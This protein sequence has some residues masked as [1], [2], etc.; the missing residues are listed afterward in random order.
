MAKIDDYRN[1]KQPLPKQY[2]AWQVFGA[3][4]ENVGR[5]GKPTTIEM[6]EPE[7]NEILIRVDVL[8]LCLSD[9]KI[10]NQ[11]S[12]HPRL[13]GRDLASDPTVLG[14][15]C[16]ATVVAVGESWKDT[17]KIGQRYIVQADHLLQ[18]RGLRIRLSHP[19]RP[20]PVLLSRR[21]RSG[22]R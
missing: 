18:R 14:H 3:G 17:F 5:D 15:E 20:G 21:A 22:R 2:R 4:F 10:I 19:R 1:A 16:S 13:R 8:G 11:G 6:R 7:D 12:K 9:I